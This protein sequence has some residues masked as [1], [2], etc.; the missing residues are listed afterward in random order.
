MELQCFNFVQLY[1]YFLLSKKLW[2]SHCWL[3]MKS[4]LEDGDYSEHE[5][6]YDDALAGELLA[7]AHSVK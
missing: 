3:K 2:N 6:D 5:N 7:D 1:L 4:E